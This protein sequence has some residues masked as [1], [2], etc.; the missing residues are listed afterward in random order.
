MDYHT[1]TWTVGTK[2]SSDLIFA[3]SRQVN[4]LLT[5][6]W[7][8]DCDLLLNTVVIKVNNLAPQHAELGGG[9][10]DCVRTF[11]LDS[12]NT[13]TV[14]LIPTQPTVATGAA[15]DYQISLI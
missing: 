4:V 5:I 3:S 15:G 10:R 8:T 9:T 12:V 6:R 11:V 2:D 14:N 7:T 13:I 1:G